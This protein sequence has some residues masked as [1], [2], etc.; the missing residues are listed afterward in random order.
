MSLGVVMLDI[1]GTTLTDTD[2]QI[3]KHPL[4]GGVILFSRNYQ[5]IQQLTQ[6]TADIHSLRTPPLLI[7]VDH[8]GG[9]VQRFREGFTPLP[10]CAIYG[11]L[12]DKDP[13]WA[14]HLAEQAGWLLAVELRAVGVDLSFAPVLDIH[15]GVSKVIDN[16]AFHRDPDAVSQL[17]RAMMQGM[18]RAGMAAVGKHFP[19]HG[20]VVEDSHHELPIDSRN[21][22]DLLLEDLIP[23]QRLIHY[24]L[25][26]IMTAHLKIPSFD[27]RPVSF[28]E[29]WLKQVL[30]NELGFQGAIFSDDLSM[31]GARGNGSIVER[32]KAALNAGCD[33]VL[34]CN[35]RPAAMDLLLHLGS[36]EAPA[37]Q[38]RLLRLHGRKHWDKLHHL[39]EWQTAHQLISSLEVYPELAL[40]SI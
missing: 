19:G 33:M 26:A 36:W 3:L 32:A 15:R 34:V 6:L 39:S 14:C 2:R 25:P 31:G 4:V 11:D 8:E 22:A 40:N 17:A 5:N 18:K 13:A 28:S 12:F 30:R 24:G 1:E 23:F 37:S 9:R 27:D 7:A 20:G 10:P 29:K 16:R 38:I 21:I 35:D